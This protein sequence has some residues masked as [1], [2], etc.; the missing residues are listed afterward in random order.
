MVT[1]FNTFKVV[2]FTC[3]S[4][5]IYARGLI[6]L[7]GYG[8]GMMNGG[9]MGG[10]MMGG[11]MMNPGMMGGGLYQQKQS[12]GGLF[13]G[14]GGHLLTGFAGYQLARAIG[15]GGS[16]HQSTQHIYH[17]HETPQQAVTPDQY[18]QT[19]NAQS[20]NQQTIQSPAPAGSPVG[21]IAP[22]APN[23]A[24]QY[25][26]GQP[27]PSVPLA[28]FPNESTNCTENCT[29]AGKVAETVTPVPEFSNEYSTIHPS[30]FPYAT[31]SEHL[32]YWATSHNKA[33]N[34]TTPDTTDSSILSTTISS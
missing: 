33:L 16:H 29:E 3:V 27:M 24:T 15:G 5:L 7:G 30:L 4:F 2:L 13:S 28:P 18:Q 14:I 34:L 11:G 6:F 17:H 31:F 12:G 23:Q 21:T 22:A 1:C 32:P 25:M 10:G 9:M 19:I 8:G 26:Y 20:N